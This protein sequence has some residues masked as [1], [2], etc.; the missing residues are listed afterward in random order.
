MTDNTKPYALTYPRRVVLRFFMRLA[1][2]LL[3][4]LLT[5]TT[6]IGRENLPKGGPL[7]LVGNHVAIM[8]VIMMALYVDYPIEMIGTGDIPIDPRFAWMTG[9]WG[10]IPVR[11]GSV[12]R[13]EMRLPI[14]VLKQGGVVGI[15]PEGGIWETKMK[16]ARTGVAWLSYHANAP[17]VPIGF[18]GMKGA[19]GAALS[20]RRPALVMNIGRPMPPVSVRVEGM[21]RKEALEFAA[22]NIMAHVEALIPEA[23]K[24]D[25]QQIQD[26]S[27]DFTIVISSRNRAGQTFEEEK[28][29]MHPKGLGKFFHRPVILDVMARNMNLPVRPLQELAK[30]H[31]AARISEALD[32]AIG[33]LDEN[34]YF[35][36]YRF[37]YDEARDMY[38][39]VVE[40]RDIAR[41][42]AAHGQ[43]I[44][45]RP[46]RTYRRA[47]DNAEITE[48]VPGVMHEM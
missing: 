22:N 43:Q 47:G 16:K 11:R 26:E 33:F 15:F 38:A 34:P 2:R 30:E 13:E 35:L 45:L 10:F 46:R 28:A 44:T 17:V 36:S 39:G 8:E 7:I 29:V 37:G 18:G 5:R 1:G 24:R 12:D 3:M 41:E 25:W 20:L 21:S 4:R 27:F 42:A 40:L 31:D 14:D 19:L 23:E 48:I 32:V 6:I 9:L